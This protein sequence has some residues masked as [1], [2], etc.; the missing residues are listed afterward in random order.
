MRR[1][2]YAIAALAACAIGTALAAAPEPQFPESNKA[3]AV[4]PV[5]EAPNAV[6]SVLFELPEGTRFKTGNRKVDG[7]TTWVNI[8][9]KDG[10][11]GWANGGLMCDGYYGLPP[12]VPTDAAGN[13]EYREVV[14]VPDTPADELYRRAKLWLAVAYRSAPDV[15]KLD[16][17]AGGAIVAKGIFPV[18][19]PGVVPTVDTRHTLTLEFKDGRY[20]VTVN[21]LELAVLWGFT[22]AGTPVEVFVAAGLTGKWRVTYLESLDEDIRGTLADLNASMQKTGTDDDW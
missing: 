4:L 11:T 18:A 8:R 12:T 16:D 22:P 13:I 15:T 2:A 10:R 9:T 1:A 3:C 21:Q 5:R 14:E 19:L 20:R 7:R 6:A 17:A